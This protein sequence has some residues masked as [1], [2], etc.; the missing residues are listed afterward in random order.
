MFKNE[1]AFPIRLTKLR[2][3]LTVTCNAARMTIRYGAR[4]FRRKH[5]V[6]IL[7]VILL[8]ACT[9]WRE[10]TLIRADRIRPIQGPDDLSTEN[11]QSSGEQKAIRAIE[12]RK[13]ADLQ[14]KR[15]DSKAALIIV[16][17]KKEELLLKKVGREERLVLVWLFAYKNMAGTSWLGVTVGYDGVLDVGEKKMP[18]ESNIRSPAISDW[19]VDARDLARKP[20]NW[21]GYAY[22][23]AGSD[24]YGGVWIDSP[25]TPQI[26]VGF[27][28][29]DARSGKEIKPD[30][31]TRPYPPWDSIKVETRITVV[32]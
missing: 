7:L 3:V 25:Q 6:I 10:N 9:D 29:F 32:E 30:L 12:G 8:S 21:A 5:I 24:V 15:W 22:M 26:G 19:S 23:L 28:A 2:S 18:K 17:P 13:I 14:A 1:R 4:I 27:R 31:H 20:E 16:H 11:R